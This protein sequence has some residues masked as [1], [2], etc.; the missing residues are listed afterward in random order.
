MLPFKLNRG[1]AP[2]SG[3]S[4]KCF[5]SAS[6]LNRG[7]ALKSWGSLR[8][9]PKTCSQKCSQRLLP[10]RGGRALKSWGSLNVF[11]NV[12]PDVLPES[13]GSK[14][15]SQT[16][17]QNRGGP[18]ACTYLLQPCD[19]YYL[20]ARP[21][22]FRKFTFFSKKSPKSSKIT[23]KTWDSLILHLFRP[24]SLDFMLPGTLVEKCA[25]YQ[26]KHQTPSD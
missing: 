21:S 9:A 14:T 10:N 24:P 16:C 19:L 25:S 12:L 6:K 8:R 23:S 11:S 18:P 4:Q 13:W 2:K 15:C 22:S 5:Q 26:F 17:S 3:G 7:G 1:G 20:F